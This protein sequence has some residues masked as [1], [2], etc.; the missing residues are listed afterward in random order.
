M[1]R[2]KL[3]A[4][5]ARSSNHVRENCFFIH[6]PK[7]AGSSFRDSVEKKREV[8]KDYG[9]SAN[10]TADVIK[11][12]VYGNTDLFQFRAFLLN[13]KKYWL[14]G[15]VPLAKYVDCIPLI[16]TVLFVRSPLE[17]VLSHFNHYVALHD[18]KG[19]LNEFL[20]KAFTKNFQSKF[21]SYVP[22]SLVGCVGITENYD[23]SLAIINDHLKTK[24]KS[25]KI[26]V[27]KKKSY[28]S[29][30]LA[31]ELY[32]KFFENN[33]D[34][35]AMYEEALFLHEQR[36]KLLAEKKLWTYS[37]AKI[38]KNNVL[39]GCAYRS[40]SDEVVELHIELNGEKFREIRACHYFDSY[41]KVNFPRA[42]YIGFN[43]PLPKNLTTKD[44]VDI[45]VKDTGQKIN[46]KPLRVVA[47]T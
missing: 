6:I 35:L 5:L 44:E 33:Q 1:I 40:K 20:D 47:Q 43:I 12:L 45:Y 28:T 15:H 42:R 10:S 26:N 16:N 30:E 36:V 46:F 3:K 32:V 2:N 29:I 34:D 11:S 39:A 21:I 41:P 18:F 14:A 22:L 25:Q 19:D 38:N 31:G 27:N 23:D 7:T 13:K 9:H 17:Q 4:A 24:F 8:L 37:T